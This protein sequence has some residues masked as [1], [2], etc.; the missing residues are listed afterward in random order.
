MAPYFADKSTVPATE[1]SILK[2]LIRTP[3]QTTIMSF[4]TRARTKS[5]KKAKCSF[6]TPTTPPPSKNRYYR[7]LQPLSEMELQEHPIIWNTVSIT[8]VKPI[9]SPSVSNTEI[10]TEGQLGAALHKTKLSTT[11]EKSTSSTDLVDLKQCSQETPITPIPPP[12]PSQQAPITTSTTEQ[13]LSKKPKTIQKRHINESP[14]W[15]K[16]QGKQKGMSSKDGG[17]RSQ[18]TKA[19]GSERAARLPQFRKSI[20]YQEASKQAL[21]Q[22]LQNVNLMDQQQQVHRKRNSASDEVVTIKV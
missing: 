13:K 3:W 17:Q 11:R 18:T 19:K 1:Q 10:L 4:G 20:N 16:R 12:Q 7:Q 15:E 6:Y 21:D 2:F 8:K 9:D 14:E 5:T 22:F